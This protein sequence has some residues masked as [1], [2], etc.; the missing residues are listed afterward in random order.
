[1]ASLGAGLGYTLS[2]DEK[3]P[4]RL[5]WLEDGQT[6]YTFT[7]L[8]SAVVGRLLRQDPAPLVKSCLVLPGGRAGLLAYKLERD[9]LL[10]AMAEHWRILKFRHLRRLAGLAG[11][12]RAGFEK[13]L[14]SDPIEPPEQ[15][16]MF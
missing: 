6:I 9:P 3:N 12:T 13:E 4:R 5:S 11:L 16:K 7:L 10:R 1:M 15:M 14:S 8:A 2:R